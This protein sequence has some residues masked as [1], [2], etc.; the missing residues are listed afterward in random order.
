MWI[1]VAVI[2]VS[3]LAVYA[4]MQQAMFGKKP[5]GK[6]LA[7]IEKSVNYK[8]GSFQNLSRTPSLTNGATYFGVLRDFLFAKHE[9]MVPEDIIPTKKTDL[10]QLNRSQEVLVWF[11]HSSYFMQVDGKRILV[12]PVLSG[13]ASPMPRGTKAFNG[14]DV[15]TIDEIPEIDILFISHD[16]W[17]HLDYRTITKLKPKIKQVICGLGTGEHLEYWGY[18]PEII[19]EKDWYEE[20]ELGDGFKVY[21]TPARH[22]SG[23]TF[24]RNKALWMSYV[25]KTPTMQIFIGGDSGYDKH[26]KE[27]GNTFGGFDLAILENGQYNK[28]WQ[29]IHTLPEELLQVAKDLRAKRILPVHSAKFK[30][31]THA[32]DEPLKKAAENGKRENISVLT[33]MIGEQVDLKNEKQQ[34]SEWWLG[35]N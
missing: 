30:L 25:L 5:R 15:Y 16:H 22:F 17:D 35:V 6:R 1:V 18:S 29:H 7:R 4:F 24:V 27:I 3:I 19:I 11:G 9:R 12:D 14:T 20:I 33:P 23:R 8:D 34:F 26:F 21:T 31:S 2:V 32:W 10:H 13:S 28:S